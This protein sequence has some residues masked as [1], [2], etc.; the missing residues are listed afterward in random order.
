MN[1]LRVELLAAVVAGMAFGGISS[2]AVAAPAST[3]NATLVD[4]GQCTFT[5]T[6]SW[7]NAKVSTVYARLY[8]DDTFVATLAAPGTGPNAGT[9]RGRTAVFVAGPFVPVSSSSNWTAL[10]DYYSE[11][12]AQLN[13]TYTNLDVVPCG[14][15]AP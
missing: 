11:A 1:S 7:K 8:V 6:A 15:P 4:D 12:G 5:V 9:L 3:F 14:V 10:I 13:Q 2:A